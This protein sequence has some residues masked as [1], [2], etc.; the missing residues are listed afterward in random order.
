MVDKATL[1]EFKYELDCF[2][3]SVDMIL[4]GKYREHPL[5]SFL[6]E[7]CLLHFR[8]VWDFFYMG[9]KNNNLTVRD[10]LRGGIPKKLRPKQPPRLVEIRERLGETLAH[11]SIRRAT[12]EFKE[13]PIKHSDIPLMRDH[14]TNLFVA[15]AGLLTQ[16][17]R[18]ALVNPLASKFAKYKTLR[19]QE[20]SL[21]TGSSRREQHRDR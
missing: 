21:A 11:L 20:T 3:A 18:D 7:V 12:K 10:F 14:I 5:D 15:F 17:E 9:K 1:G 4:S 16:D 13:A 8:V 2:T 19:P 6:L